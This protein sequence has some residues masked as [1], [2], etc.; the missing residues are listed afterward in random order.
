MPLP[1]VP[2]WRGIRI[3]KRSGRRQA[4]KCK[5]RVVDD[6]PSPMSLGTDQC[7]NKNGDYT[8]KMRRQMEKVLSESHVNTW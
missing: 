7:S 1:E 3:F 2:A 8:V 4:S 5:W 6:N